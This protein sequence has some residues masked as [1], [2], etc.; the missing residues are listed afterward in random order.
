MSETVTV[1]FATNREEIRK[2]GVVIGFGK[3]PHQNSALWLR[4][5]AAEMVARADGDGFDLA[6][7]RVAREAI[8]DGSRAGAKPVL[9]SQEVFDGLRERLAA[10]RADLVALI[11]GFAST[12]ESALSNA[13]E[14]KVKLSTRDLP[15]ETA[16]FCWPSDGTLFPFWAAYYADRRDVRESAA[17]AVAALKGTAKESAPLIG[18]V[19]M[20]DDARSAAKAAERALLRMRSYLLGLP[21]E[22]MCDRNMHLIA[23]SMGNYMLRHA[24]QALISDLGEKRLP[25]LFKNIFLMAA[26]EDDDA[27]EHEGKFARLPELAEAVHVYFARNDRALTVS[28]VTKGNRDRLGTAGP[29][30]LAV[31][32]HKVVLV[33]CTD[34]SETGSVFDAGHQ[35]YRKR[36]EVLA[37]MRAVLSGLPPERVPN[38]VW[39]P[40]RSCW[41]IRPAG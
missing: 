25:R 11:H 22:E 26:D 31:V 33:D 17:A 13:A 40:E 10:N 32:P 28:D 27:F 19:S 41:R 2:R 16:A 34:V 35:Y 3:R 7:L 24:L 37:D 12:F 14:L 8:P 21:R 36:P 5:G 20:R 18:D 6:E 39:V 23:H 30:T 4:Y 9:G 38:R 1:H 29:R 15:V